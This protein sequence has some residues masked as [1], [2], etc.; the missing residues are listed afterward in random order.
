LH[1]INAALHQLTWG[2]IAMMNRIE[3]I[4]EN[5]KAE[6]RLLADRAIA[7]MRN[8]GLETA[9]LITSAK[10]P[11]RV[12]ADTGLKF[13]TLT[14]K[15]IEK[16]LK[17]QAA[18][19]EELIDGSADRVEMAARAV[20]MRVLVEA[21]ISTLPTSRDHVV[22]N[23]RKTVAIVRDTGDAL[24]ELVKE[25]VVDISSAR[26]RRTPAARKAAGRPAAKKKAPGRKPAAKKAARGKPAARKAAPRKAA[27]RKAGAR[28]AAP[29]KA[30]AAASAPVAQA[31]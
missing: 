3:Q 24:G 2:P 7:R 31:A 20:S 30:S 8:A 10:T 16:L 21:Q 12:A 4:A 11:V 13:N 15:S 5:L 27:A 22:D 9:S 29:R 28:K 14:H 1:C 23:A 25:A 6:S 17:Q 26:T 18:A 19:L